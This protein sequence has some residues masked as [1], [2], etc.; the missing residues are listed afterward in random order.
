MP[1]GYNNKILHVDL[2]TGKLEIEEPG[3]LFYRKYMGGSAMAL[4][5]ILKNTPVGAD[6]LGPE[7]TL[8]LA[9]GILTGAPISGQSRVSAH[10]RSPLSGAIGD[11]QAGGFWPAECKAAGFDAIVIK[12]RSERPVYLWLHDGEAEIRPADHLWGKVTGEAEALIREELREKRAEVLQIGPAGERLVRFA[13]LINMCNRA[14]GRT[15]MGAVMGSKNL[16]AVVV[17]GR[18]RPKVADPEAVRKLAQWGSEH[19]PQSGVYGMGVYGT[20]EVVAYQNTAGGLPTRNWSSG[21]F[22][23]YENITGE[24][25]A[26]TI[27]KKRDTCY[28]CIVRC[29]RVVE[30]TEGPYQVEPLYGGPE[31]ET[32]STLGSYCG[33]DN[34]AAIARANQICNQYGMDTISCGATVAFAMDCFERG[35]LTLKDTDGIELRFGNAAAMVEMVGRIARREGLGNLLAEGSVR[36]AEKIGRGAEELAVAVKKHELPAHMPQVKRSLGLIYA[37]NPFGADH[38]SSEHDPAYESD[39][40]IFAERLGSMDLLEPRPLYSLD[41]EKVRFALYTQYIYSA[42]NTLGLCQFVWGP[43][44]QLYGPSQMAELARAVTGWDVSLWE[45]MKVGERSLNLERAYNAREGFNRTHD[46]LPPKL[47]QPLTGGPSDGMSFTAQD[48]EQ[49]L[50][51]YYAMCGW[52]RNGLPTRS[53]LDELSIGWVADELK[54]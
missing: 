44:W 24:R 5:Y 15:G 11:S 8:V 48:L 51:T 46:V 19:F 29:K 4:Y 42:D 16:K 50:D 31:Y 47:A 43:A 21:V 37:V 33:V 6:P 18:K 14:N 9:T 12:G 23:G 40:K 26:D 2:T 30:V 53:K 1:Y 35:I 39:Y 38:Q 17:R 32:I 41:A 28:G 22:E 52:D 13:A 10:A 36:A 20:A 7:N 49:A 34:L 45:L 3:E 25:M 27:L 54:L